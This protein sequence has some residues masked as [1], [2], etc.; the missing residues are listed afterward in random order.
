M[1]VEKKKHYCSVISFITLFHSNRKP[2]K[3]VK[4]KLINIKTYIQFISCRPSYCKAKIC[5]LFKEHRCPRYHFPKNGSFMAQD[6]HIHWH[7]PSYL[8][9]SDTHSVQI[10]RMFTYWFL[11][12]Q[13]WVHCPQLL[14]N[15]KV[16]APFLLPQMLK[17]HLTMKDW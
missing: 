17:I 2:S 16:L 8:P 15:H 6:A 12:Q 4:T 10:S 3:N 14:Q 1:S 9:R 5:I 11:Q 13:K 7:M